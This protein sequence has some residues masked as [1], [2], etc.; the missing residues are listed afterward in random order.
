MKAAALPFLCAL[1]LFTVAQTANAAL[2]TTVDRATFQ[3]SIIAATIDVQDF[4]SLAPDSVLVSDG[5]V[6]YITSGGAGFVTDD[7]AT[8]TPP[9]GLGSTSTLS[10]ILGSG[11]EQATFDFANPITA[12][13]IDIITSA[14]GDGAYQANISTGD[15]LNSIAQV[16][17]GGPTGQFIGFTSDT[18]FTAVTISALTGFDYTLDT[19]AFGQ[20]S[21]LNE[22][23]TDV[24]DVPAPDA[25]LILSVGLLGIGWA[26]RRRQR[27][28]ARR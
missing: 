17:P 1:G 16:F 18:P 26:Q 22:G 3:A 13:A 14:A 19:L 20:S 15:N 9:N 4:D 11:G 10:A 8:S 21:G 2:I 27:R 5:D 7:F 12:F 23:P 28:S 24:T 6:T 25:L